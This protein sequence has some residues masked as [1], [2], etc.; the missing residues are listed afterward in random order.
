[1]R[2]SHPKIIKL[3]LLNFLIAA[4]TYASSETTLLLKSQ[5]PHAM[6]LHSPSI[7]SL[8]A[9][10]PYITPGRVEAI[11]A[12]LVNYHWVP[13][14]GLFLSFVGTSDPKLA[15]QASTYDQAA[16]GLLAIR[17]GDL[18]RAKGISEFFR[19]AW[20]TG[21]MQPGYRAGVS[22][23][24]NF[25]NAEFGGEGI[26]T[27]IHVGPN[28][29]MGLFAAR[30]GNTA[31]DKD[32]FNLALD[33]AGWIAHDIP[34][35][36]GGVSMGP[37]DDTG[38]APWRKILSTENNLSYYALLSEL[39]RSSMLDESSRVWISEE[40]DHVSKW[41]TG[42]AFDP[43]AYAM[44]RGVT[45]EG[46]DRIRALDTVTW[47]ISAIGP[48]NL[49]QS[50]IDPD[51]LM[52][53]AERAFEVKVG[54]RLGVDP[55]DKPEADLTNRTRLIWYEGMGQYIN[56][57]NT[58]ASCARKQGNALLARHYFDKAR[59]MTENFDL[60]ALPHKSGAAYPYATAGKFFHDGWASPPDGIDSPASSLIASVWRCFAGLGEDPLAGGHIDGVHPVSINIAEIRT[61]NHPRPR[62]LYGNSEQMTVR[63]WK[64]LD[65]HDLKTAI[66]QAEAVIE[67]WRSFAIA[68]QQKKLNEIGQTVHY[69]GFTDDKQKI[70][71]YWA[72]NDVGAA[73]FI[74]GKAF[75]LKH[76]YDNAAQAFKEIALHYSLAQVWDPRG[77]FWSPVDAIRNEYALRDSRHYGN[78]VPEIVADSNIQGKQPD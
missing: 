1:M 38:S 30:L 21:P 78:I 45:P 62:I 39:L 76:E 77:W 7:T 47:L 43:L 20:A 69:D 17:L 55:T 40:R 71:K 32:S 16:V 12:N 54:D 42:Y 60:A 13:Q 5:L 27:T 15:Q 23:L 26:E 57:L 8:K 10:A 2:T 72:L 29:W 53:G 44:N 65:Q 58:M 75:D 56:S 24:S 49:R 68:L 31:H 25:Y 34:H 46:E 64:A 11:Y 48:D 74:L 22:G 6:L 3:L 18:K 70:F 63:A 28:A 36:N 61:V 73:Y 37:L 66:D 51:R 52:R 41:L 59:I 19:K 14:T 9:V 50:G 4:I 67:Q 35:M 33:I